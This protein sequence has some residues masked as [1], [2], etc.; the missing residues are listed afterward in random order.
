MLGTHGSF[1]SCHE[2]QDL[3]PDNR[4]CDWG[5]T[6][7]DPWLRACCSP[8]NDSAYC[9]KTAYNKCSPSFSE[10]G[11]SYYSFCPLTNNTMCGTKKA[12]EKLYGDGAVVLQ[13]S[14]RKLSFSN[15]DLRWFQKHEDKL[16]RF[17]ACTYTLLQEPAD[18]FAGGNIALNVTKMSNV[19]I[20][21]SEGE[22]SEEAEA[23]AAVEGSA[24]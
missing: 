11:A 14:L 23:V 3:S 19:E 15:Q 21:L 24:E 18:L 10:A 6:I 20:Y 16:D 4:M 1:K 12:S 2:C 13:V 8:D 9:K 7:A 17:D 22:K 5:G